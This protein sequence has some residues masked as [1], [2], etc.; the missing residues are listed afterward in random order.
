M[1]SS[2]CIPNSGRSQ[3]KELGSWCGLLSDCAICPWRILSWPWGSKISGHCMI[4]SFW[5]N[6]YLNYLCSFC[7]MKQYTLKI[8]KKDSI[9]LLTQNITLRY[10]GEN[11]I[12]LVLK[13]VCNYTVWQIPNPQPHRILNM[14]NWSLRLKEVGVEDKECPRKCIDCHR[15]SFWCLMVWLNGVTFLKD[16]E[17][18]K[19]HADLREA[20]SERGKST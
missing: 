8:I 14:Q 10:F 16:W 1:S 3:Q 15:L 12:F 4:Q 7:L 9:L 20:D 5:V 19:C 6:S 17:S 2:N 13:C 18:S 11:N